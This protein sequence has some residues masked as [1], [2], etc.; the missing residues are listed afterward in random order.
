VVPGAR[1][2]ILGKQGAGKGT[3]CV[4]LSR[5]YVIAHIS[6]GEI[7]RA[8]AKSGTEF[9]RKA[10]EF[11][12][13]GELVPD[14]VVNGLVRERLTKEDTKR[15]FLLDGYPRNV[16]QAETLDAMLLPRGIDLVIDIE[17]ATEVVLMRLAGRRVCVDCGTNYSPDTP[18]QDDWSCDRCGGKVIQREDDTEF[19]IKRR[20]RL[21]EEQT[22]PL[23]AWYM[24]RDKLVSIDGVGVAAKV[25]ARIVQAI[26][27]RMRHA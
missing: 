3:Q 25:T 17:V 6:T 20:L 10:K 1:L 8:A 16:Q 5:H 14:E 19:A 23:I 7:F 4:A 18:P 13:A 15:G 26:D 27:V 21:Y 12:D 22:E 11:M 24:R 9:G 2:V